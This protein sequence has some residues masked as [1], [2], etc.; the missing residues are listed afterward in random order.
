MLISAGIA[1]GL[2]LAGAHPVAAGADR[3]VRLVPSVEI[4]DHLDGI[5][6]M[7]FLPPD[8]RWVLTSSGDSLIAWRADRPFEARTLV[9]GSRIVGH[10]VSPGGLRVAVTTV[11]GA[12]I[13]ETRT[14]RTVVRFDPEAVRELLYPIWSPVGE[15]IATMSGTHINLW[16]AVTGEMLRGIDLEDLGSRGRPRLAWAPDGERIAALG[17]TGLLR[18]YR[19]ADGALEAEARAHEGISRHIA[20]SPDGRLLAT[21]G[22][23]GLVKLWNASD[24]TLSLSRSNEGTILLNGRSQVD[25]IAFSPDSS[26][27]AVSVPAFSLR[28][29]SVTSGEVLAHW[30][31]AART[32]YTPHYGQVLDM[33]FSPDSRFLITGGLDNTAKVWDTDTRAQ[34]AV[35][36][37]FRNSVESVSWSQD[38]K[39]YAA[40]S[41]DGTA[42]VWDTAS[43]GR[44][45]TFG[46]HR[47]GTVVSLSYAPSVPRFVTAGS[48]GTV[49]VW[50]SSTGLG[51]FDVPPH[52]RPP[53]HYDRESKS[54]E[55]VVYSPTLNRVAI[56]YSGTTRDLRV[57][58]IAATPQPPVMLGYDVGAVGWSPDGGLLAIAGRYGVAV[59]NLL[60]PHARPVALA[61]PG[62]A[63]SER[64]R[65]VTWSSDGERVLAASNSGVTGWD[66]TTGRVV[67][68][69][70]G[71]QEAAYV[72]ESTDG[73]LLL[74]IDGRRGAQVLRSWD[75]TSETE[76]A[77]LEAGRGERLEARFLPGEDRVLVR[78]ASFRR[79]VPVAPRIWNPRTGET[80]VEME[81]HSWA[82]D[83][84]AVSDVADLIATAGAEREVRLWSAASGS[85]LATVPTVL[86]LV[87]GLEFSP[88]GTELA[89]YG[90]GGVQTW[91][92]ARPVE[93]SP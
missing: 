93:T 32:R 31:T 26:K 54:A 90:A 83:A 65:H 49:R 72:E 61:I 4:T 70:R 11:A 3:A 60:D 51:L 24:W 78:A 92:V 84:M 23:D 68:M 81:G 67:R 77:R 48:D 14:G 75:A 28:V 2:A 86:G 73:S 25:S 52:D 33:Q 38:G 89:A 13:L 64:F 41:S 40:A 15:R 19:V 58:A 62:A 57:R 45:S 18:V 12:M 88:D 59:A 35:P 91:R 27:I 46:G 87:R 10:A 6:T 39:R 42:R 76:L 7:E 85:P 71:L 8:G 34:L 55:R 30:S 37:G 29:W 56:Q 47:R 44:V 53:P 5:R 80:L 66:W 74:T 79:S 22:N 50:Q 82:V 16:H 63:D 9:D 21:G 43:Y 69:L 36:I 1:A 20:W 17:V